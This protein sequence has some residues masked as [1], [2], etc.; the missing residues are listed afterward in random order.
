MSFLYCYMLENFYFFRQNIFITIWV[1]L[2][3]SLLI[4]FLI[5]RLDYQ[6][7]EIG[8]VL[9]LSC[10]I[11]QNITHK[12]WIKSYSPAWKSIPTANEVPEIGIKASILSLGSRGIPLIPSWTEYIRN[13]SIP[14][15]KR[16][17]KQ[18][19]YLILKSFYWQE[20]GSRWQSRKTLNLPPPKGM[21]KLQLL[22][23]HLLMRTFWKLA[24][25]I[26]HFFLYI[27]INI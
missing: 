10:L 23:E 21:P 4:C 9:F 24:E 2:R 22:K 16:K 7:T 12:L 27:F 11:N 14:K 5:P 18:N 19:E 13:D 17:Q 3:N 8:K 6:S 20:G 15:F 1:R 26:F 25:K